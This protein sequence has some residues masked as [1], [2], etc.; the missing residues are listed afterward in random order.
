MGAQA[1]FHMCLKMIIIIEDQEDYIVFVFVVIE[2][3]KIFVRYFL[4][5]SSVW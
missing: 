4:N 2:I 1:I 3:G 5:E